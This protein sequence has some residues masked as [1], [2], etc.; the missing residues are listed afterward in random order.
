MNI[1]GTKQPPPPDAKSLAKEWKRK[2]QKESRDIDKQIANIKREE[3]RALT[4]CKRL[5]KSNHLP[6]A[7]ILAKQIAETR[8]ATERMYLAKAQLNS[9]A[10]QLQ[11][12]AC[13]FSLVVF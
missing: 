8:K 11:S 1:F 10:M 6:A 2:L 12:S 5:A 13:M 4:E 7:R 9:V 3:T